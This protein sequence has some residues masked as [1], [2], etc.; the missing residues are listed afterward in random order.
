MPP[1]GPKDMFG[2]DEA[3]PASALSDDV[4]AADDKTLRLAAPLLTA[5]RLEGFIRYQKAF[6]AR[7]TA[8][9]LKKEQVHDY[10]ADAHTAA[11]EESGLD[12][13]THAQVA[14]FVTDF[15]G[16]RTTVRALSVKLKERQK[17][18]AEIEARGDDVD[19]EELEIVGKLATEL[20]RLDRFD[21]MDRRYGPDQVALL[22]SREQELVQLHNQI[23]D[24]LNRR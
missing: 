20:V 22:R 13:P 11:L 6:L 14:A 10:L 18:V 7:I 15:C 5:E 2:F 9:P 17:K 23:H 1:S 4:L 24:L 21:P 12:L 19:P 16:K 3:V 8:A